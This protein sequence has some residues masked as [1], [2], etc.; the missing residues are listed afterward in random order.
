MQRASLRP[1][2]AP[3]CLDVPPTVSG[4]TL[5]DHA[6]PRKLPHSSL[7]CS[8]RATCVGLELCQVWP[9]CPVHALNPEE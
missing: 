3:H 5:L 2:S 6:K 1:G 8:I 7:P 4:Q 9:L